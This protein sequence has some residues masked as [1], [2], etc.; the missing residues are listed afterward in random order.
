LVA[1]VGVVGVAGGDVPDGGFGLD[2]D[3][4]R[5]VVDRVERLGGVLNLPDDHC[6]DLDRVA[7]GVIDLGHRGLL[8]ADPGGHPPP[9]GGRGGPEAGGGPG[10]G[11]GGGGG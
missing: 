9:A 4:L 10:G 3:E 11:A 1:A 5:E 8:V 6:G 7:V 2:G